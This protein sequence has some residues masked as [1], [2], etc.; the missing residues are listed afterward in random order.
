MGNKVSLDALLE[1]IQRDSLKEQTLAPLV[2]DPSAPKNLTLSR[3]NY[4]AH[5]RSQLRAAPSQP[6]ASVSAAEPTLA[7]N[8]SG[9]TPVAPATSAMPATPAPATPGLAEIPVDTRSETPLSDR[10]ELWESRL[11]DRQRALPK[12]SYQMLGGIVAILLLVFGVGSAT[13][14]TQQ[15]QD[16]RNQ[17]FEQ[18]L[19]PVSGPSAVLTQQEI[20]QQQ[21]L[22][23]TGIVDTTVQK[24]QEQIAGFELTSQS[25]AIL[26]AGGLAIFVVLA[27]LAWMS[28]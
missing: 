17:A 19:A 14:L 4:S 9:A 20:D 18:T 2:A 28:I 11:T 5:V 1:Q 3:G 21:R 24:V 16:I 23:Q 22:A 8:A 6:T 12:I 27:F 26:A 13:V 10:Q 15:S 25:F 7:L